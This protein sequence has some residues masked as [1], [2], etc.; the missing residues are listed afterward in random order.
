MKR[1]DWLNLCMWLLGICFA[2]IGNITVSSIW[3]V[4]AAIHQAIHTAL[5]GGN[6]AVGANGATDNQHEEQ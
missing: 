5:E 3:F 1:A 2:F 6:N 4:G